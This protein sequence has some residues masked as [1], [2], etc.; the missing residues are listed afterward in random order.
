M[1][2]SLT[3]RV[4]AT[5][6]VL[7]GALSSP[8]WADESQAGKLLVYIGTYTGHGSK[9]IERYRMDLATGTLTALGETPLENPSFLALDPAG[10]HLYAV[11]EIG[12]FA[13]KKAGS[14]S[15]FS[16]DRATGDLKPIGQ[17][18]SSGGDYPCHLAIDPTDKA[19]LVANYGGGS[20]GVLPI[21]ADGSLRPLSAFVQHQG[22][23]VD[24][25]RQEGP[26]AHCVQVSPDGRFALVADLGLD[27]ILVYRLNAAAGKLTPNDPPSVSIAGGS[28]PRHFA[29]SPDGKFLYVNSEMKSTVTVL[30]YAA[31]TG[32]LKIVQTASSLPAGFKGENSTAEIALGPRGRYLYCS[33]RGHDSLAIF[34]VDR[35]TGRLTPVGHQSTGGKSPRHFAIDPT[36]KYLLAANQDSANVVVFQI[37]TNGQLKP[38]G[39]EAHIDHPVCVVMLPAAP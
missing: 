17:P 21:A 31:A 34:S 37:E 24:K 12:N 30:S 15:A 22:S 27:K 13:G 7:F 14:V 9:G 5:I 39:V 36:G 11:G 2:A 16:L 29:F 20:V 32:T 18:Q 28:G 25:G 6:A 19:L 4:A 35:D 26:H 10:K 23:S 3:V 38:T 8:A 1:S 33:N